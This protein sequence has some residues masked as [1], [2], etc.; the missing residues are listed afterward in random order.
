MLFLYRIVLFSD[1]YDREITDDSNV[2]YLHGHWSLV[3]VSMLHLFLFFQLTT[4]LANFFLFFIPVISQLEFH[5]KEREINRDHIIGLEN[6]L[7]FLQGK[8]DKSLG[9]NDKLQVTE[10]RSIKVRVQWFIWKCCRM[11]ICFV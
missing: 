1:Q 5:Q 9:Q 6:N 3:T 2:K 4:I 11:Y 10:E 7:N 8:V